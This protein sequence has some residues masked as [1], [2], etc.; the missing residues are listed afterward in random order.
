MGSPVKDN[1]ASIQE[2]ANG[3]HLPAETDGNMMKNM[4]KNI[5]KNKKII[6]S[7]LSSMSVDVARKCGSANIKQYVDHGGLDEVN[8][9]KRIEMMFSCLFVLI[10]EAKEKFSGGTKRKG[11]HKDMAELCDHDKVRSK[12]YFDF[13]ARSNL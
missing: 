9:L 8:F 6:E 12:Y 7:E 4:M 3:E 5:R 1:E 13:A 11:S 10:V 2:A